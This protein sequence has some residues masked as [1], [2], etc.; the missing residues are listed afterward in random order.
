MKPNPIGLAAGV[1]V[2]VV[3]GAAC[4]AGDVTDRGAV[5][6]AG[7]AGTVTIRL[8]AFQPARVEVPAGGTVTWRQEDVATHTVTSGRV[9]QAGGTVTATVDGTF[10]SGNLTQGQQFRFTFP[11]PGQFGFYCAIHPATMTGVVTVN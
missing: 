7:D 6:S 1:A 10:D 4:G 2:L 8:I 9:D 3:T 5:E 11:E